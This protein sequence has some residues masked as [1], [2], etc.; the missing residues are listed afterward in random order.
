M[1]ENGYIRKIDEL[2]RI[3]IPKELR[4][5]LKIQDGENLIINYVDKKINLSKYSYIGNNL[6][7]IKTMGDKI[8]FLMNVDIIITDVENIIYNSNNNKNPKF[9]KK[10]LEYIKNRESTTLT[11]YKVNEDIDLIGKI[12][13]EPI[14]SN[15]LG[16]GLVIFSTNKKL[17]YTRNLCK[18]TAEMISCHINIT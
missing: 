13:I 16:I 1:N 2:G 17:D 7:Y 8:H 6:E 14:I 11:N 4:Q 12:Y 18:L 15:S 3:V 5:R 9:D 10:L